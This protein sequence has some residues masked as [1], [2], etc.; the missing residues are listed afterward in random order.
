MRRVS[1]NEDGAVAVMTAL[2]IVFLL[3]VAAIVI[4]V[5]M[6]YV[7]RFQL[8]NGADAAALAIAQDCAVG[9]C[10]QT[11]ATATE[12]A[13]K[14]A[15]DGV[16]GATAV[17]SDNNTV[18]VRTK[19]ATPDGGTAVKHWLAPILGIDSTQVQAVAK[20]SWG[21]PSK[22][23]VFPFTAPRCMFDTAPKDTELWITST[24]TCTGTG[25][26]SLPGAF[27]WLDETDKK[28]CRASVDVDQIMTG[29]PGKSGPTNCNVDGSTI[30][31]PVYD[32]KSGQGNNVY[33]S[34][35]GFAAF[36]VTAHSWP[37]QQLS[38]SDCNKCT[39]IR[40]TFIT[41]VS[42]ADLQTYGV[43]ELGGDSFNAFFVTLS[44]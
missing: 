32:S 13:G 14:N 35:A 22:A 5:G 7:E 42:L 38:V 1:G 4:D 25:G 37:N 17:I 21:S 19:T 34:I 12:L 15:N 44:L 29:E 36:K 41:L 10:S 9:N 23:T 40:G 28:S 8:Q 26:K 16:S 3:G 33:Y 2:L 43:E 39:G 30:L 24:S 31:L 6:I 27:G 20:A 18:T 11:A